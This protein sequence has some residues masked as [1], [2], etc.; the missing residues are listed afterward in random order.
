MMQ[1]KG[2]VQYLGLGRGGEGKA[3]DSTSAKQS[4][5][6]ASLARLMDGHHDLMGWNRGMKSASGLRMRG[7]LQ[8]SEGMSRRTRTRWV[9]P[10]RVGRV[11]TMTATR[12]TADDPVLTCPFAKQATRTRLLRSTGCSPL[13]GRYCNAGNLKGLPTADIR[14]LKNLTIISGAVRSRT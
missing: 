9:A 7:R 4:R 13:A 5:G 2:F 8:V 6:L 14:L 10:L 3:I 1:R 12:A 11:P